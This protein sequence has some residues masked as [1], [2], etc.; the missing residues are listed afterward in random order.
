MAFTALSNPL[1]HTPLQMVAGW[2]PSGFMSTDSLKDVVSRAVPGSWVE[3]PNYWAVA[4]DYAVRAPHAVRPRRLAAG[5]DRG[6]RRGLVRDPGLL[7]AREDRPAALRGR[8]RLLRV[9][10]WTWWPVA[11]S[12]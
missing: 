1:R 7:Q 11:G 10:H 12:I 4:C 3:H 6:R 5:G 8:R 2:L 9:E